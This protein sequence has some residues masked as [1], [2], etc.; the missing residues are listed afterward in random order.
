[1]VAA[2]NIIIIVLLVLMLAI[3]LYSAFVAAGKYDD[4]TENYE[5]EHHRKEGQKNECNGILE[6][7][8]ETSNDNSKL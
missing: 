3:A 1:M 6:S 4:K 8:E 5:K 7:A 2:N